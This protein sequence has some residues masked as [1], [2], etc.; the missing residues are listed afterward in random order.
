MKN[1]K[2]SV[3]FSKYLTGSA[4]SYLVFVTAVF[5]V[6]GVICAGLFLGW[7]G[8]VDPVSAYIMGTELFH[9]MIRTASAAAAMTLLIDFLSRRYG[10][11]NQ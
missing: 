1:Q 9:S 4:Q 7:F 11:T 8:D 10:D 6:A 2:I 3:N 5:T